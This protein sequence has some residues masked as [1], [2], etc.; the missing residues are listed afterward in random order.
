[1]E[2]K[3]TSFL[4][5]EQG[6]GSEMNTIIVQAVLTENQERITSEFELL[7]NQGFK[8]NHIEPDVIEAEFLT[9]DYDTAMRTIQ[10]LRDA[11]YTFE[12]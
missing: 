7:A 4:R 8:F 2:R 3:I 6:D 12:V 1:M 10:T 5:R 9:P 11:G